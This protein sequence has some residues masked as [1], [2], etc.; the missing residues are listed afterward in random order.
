MGNATK[1]PT[2]SQMKYFYWLNLP[3]LT[4]GLGVS[5]SDDHPRW[6]QPPLDENGSLITGGFS[7]I[8]RNKAGKTEQIWVPESAVDADGL[9]ADNVIRGIDPK[10]IDYTVGNA[11][12]IL[13]LDG[14]SHIACGVTAQSGE[15]IRAA[16]QGLIASGGTTFII[17]VDAAGVATLAASNGVGTSLGFVRRNN[18]NGKAEYS[19][20]GSVWNTIDSVTASNLVIVSNSDTTPSNLNA[21]TASG[22]GI[23]RAILNPGGNEQLQF[24]VLGTLAQI[25]SDVT[26]TAT[27]INQALDGI[28]VNVTFT[29]LNTLTAGPASNADALHTHTAPTFGFVAAEA[30]N[31][32]SNTQAV[33]LLG[34]LWKK[35]IFINALARLYFDP[36]VGTERRVGDAD[37]NTRLAQSF[38]I[39]DADAAITL[40]NVTLLI[41]KVGTPSDNVTIEVQTDS[42]GS[43]SGTVV[44]NGTSANTTGG[45]LTTFKQPIKFTWVTP[46]TLTTGVTYWLVIRRSTAN[47]AANYYKIQDAGASTYAGGSA[48]TY[49]ASTLAW[50]AIA[51]DVQMQI[52]ANMDYD[53]KVIK[54]K[55]DDLKKTNFVGLSTDNK[56]AGQTLAVGVSAYKEGFTGPLV[57]GSKYYLD[58]TAGLITATKN[59]TINSLPAIEVGQAI[60]TDT[61]LINVV[62]EYLYQATSSLNGAVLQFV[63]TGGGAFTGT[64][65]LFVELG[66]QPEEIEMDYYMDPTT[67]ANNESAIHTKFIGTQQMATQVITLLASTGAFVTVATL[68]DK[69]NTPVPD[70]VVVQ[71][72][73]QNGVYLRFN[74]DNADQVYYN[75]QF[76]ARG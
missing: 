7:L 16:I 48:K 37:A 11:D 28:S 18:G 27:E 46:P 15:L 17:G 64:F 21:K 30:I 57:R 14:G 38:V 9:G 56:T 53:G 4:V 33:S 25:V 65:D 71:E 52:I 8:V 55:Q 44:T 40:E 61:I 13:A 22:T 60:D 31:G 5:A 2:A 51:N 72:I 6:S 63:E 29:N 10:G 26:A 49:T 41:E 19:N 68:Y 69:T 73:C 50:A 62:K 3:V 67:T 1:L 36:G 58:T 76:S 34:E 32:S 20:D 74:F 70:F 75:V 35:P 45:S 23:V 43:P 42:G 24:T 47:D 54:G 66:F 39:T 12:F 59:I